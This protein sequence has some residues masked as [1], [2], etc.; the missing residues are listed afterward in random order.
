MNKEVNVVLVRVQIIG[1]GFID[2]VGLCFCINY[3]IMF[4]LKEKKYNF[5][6][7]LVYKLDIGK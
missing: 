5:V 1:L 2:V 3:R 6:G 4:E 7:K